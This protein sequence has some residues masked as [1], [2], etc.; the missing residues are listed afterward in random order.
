MIITILAE[1][2]SGSTNLANW[3]ISNKSFTILFEPITSPWWKW[4]KHG[5]PPKLWKYETP[6][7]LVKEIYRP[8]V[9][10]SELIEISDK[11]IILYRENTIQQT[12]S[13]LNANKTNNWDK[14]WIF[15]ENLIN[16]ENSVYFNEIKK[17]IKED[18][19]NKD[20]F[21]ISYEEL[22][23]NNGFQ[24]V[25]DYLNIDSVKNEN[26][27]YGSK[28]RIDAVPNKLI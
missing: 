11:L 25:I 15:N 19:L 8:G 9:D 21:N 1:P 20:Y 24:K 26:F 4:Y 10:L 5:V 17:G 27:P 7:L 23:Y 12:E 6:N 13:W 2:R 3:F 22:Y 28:Y 16:N 14:N 18:Y